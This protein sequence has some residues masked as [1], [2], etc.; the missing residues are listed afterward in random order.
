ML[1]DQPD[2][3]FGCSVDGCMGVDDQPVFMGGIGCIMVGCMGAN[4]PKPL[5]TVLVLL[6]APGKVEGGVGLSV[7]NVLRL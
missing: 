4:E 2:A 6:R 3:V 1:D 7:A 5:A